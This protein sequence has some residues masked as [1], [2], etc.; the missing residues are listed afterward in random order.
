[1]NGNPWIS[2]SKWG[3]SD[4]LQFARTCKLCGLLGKQLCGM[5]CPHLPAWIP[6]HPAVLDLNVQRERER[7]T[8]R[9]RVRCACACLHAASDGVYSTI[10]VVWQSRPVNFLMERVKKSGWEALGFLTQD[11]LSCR[12]G[13][14]SWH[15]IKN[16]SVWLSHWNL[17]FSRSWLRV[18]RF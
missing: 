1:M 6:G 14:H 3:R 18:P 17:L 4:F 9:K 5:K 7:S 15:L 10:R 13:V 16:C 2:Y 12:R 8:C 11:F